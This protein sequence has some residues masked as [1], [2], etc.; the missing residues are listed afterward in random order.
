M[1]MNWKRGARSEDKMNAESGR[2]AAV[3]LSERPARIWEIDF[4]RGLSIILMVFYHALFDL[5][6]LAGMK[7]LL[8]VPIDLSSPGWTAAQYFFA[9]LFVILSGIS[10]TLTRNNVRRSLKI[11]AAALLV[12][13]VTFFFNPASTIYFGILHCLALSILIYGLTLQKAGPL[14]SAAT[15]AAV[16]VLSS[17]RALLMR[18]VQVP[19]DWLL[20]FG[21]YSPEFSS[22]DYFPLLPW[23]GIFLAGAA[24]G[25]SIYAP[26]R[27]LIPIRVRETVINGAGRH[28]LLIYI[29]HQPVIMGLLYA[30]RLLK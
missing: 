8:G 9:S 14:A 16:L 7:T 25:K 30:L 12:T 6:D 18:G 17:A 2:A 27:S 10:S 4:L 20:P 26:K 23:F 15:G 21:I 24:L 29:V 22:F 13:A 5:S 11:L 1:D 28:S 3:T 19:F